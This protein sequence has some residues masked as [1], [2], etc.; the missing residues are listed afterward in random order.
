LACR[1]SGVAR[2]ASASTGASVVAPGYGGTLDVPAPFDR[3]LHPALTALGADRGA[4]QVIMNATDRI[5]VDFE[6]A[7]VDVD[8][9]GD[10]AALTRASPPDLPE[11]SSTVAPCAL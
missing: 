9:P 2:F 11:L 7:A 6:G 10:L 8:T 3:A 4:R 5:V 1:A